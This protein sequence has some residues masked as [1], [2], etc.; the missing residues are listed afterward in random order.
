MILIDV[1][2]KIEMTVDELLEKRLEA[3]KAKDF[4]LSDQIRGLLD[5]MNIFVF[6]LKDFQEVYYLHDKYFENM[7]KIEKIIGKEFK[8]KREFVEFKIKQDIL[9]EKTFEAWLYTMSVSRHKSS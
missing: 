5:D 6:D 8:S 1:K 2:I 4:K 7:R 9:A 3:R